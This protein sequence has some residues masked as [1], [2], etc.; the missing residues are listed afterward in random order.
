M[1][2]SGSVCPLGF[3]FEEDQQFSV[4]SFLCFW[5]LVC[6]SSQNGLN[7]L[8]LAAKEGHVG[9]VQ[10]LLGRGSSVDSATKVMFMLVGF[11]FL[12][13]RKCFKASFPWFCIAKFCGNTKILSN[14]ELKWNPVHQ[15]F[16]CVNYFHLRLIGA[17]RILYLCFLVFCLFHLIHV[18][19]R[20]T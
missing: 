14:T 11:I 6:F 5:S 12:E 4:S 20:L 10:E 19:T 3:V 16:Q 17:W 8:H 9:L 15:T 2:G 1:K 7:A 18:E 13:K